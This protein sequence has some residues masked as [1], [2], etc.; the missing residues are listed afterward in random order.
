MLCSLNPLP[1]TNGDASF[2]PLFVAEFNR[3]RPQSRGQFSNRRRNRLDFID[4]CARA[5][6]RRTVFASPL[7]SLAPCSRHGSGRPLFLPSFL[8]PA[9]PVAAKKSDRCTQAVLTALVKA[10]AATALALRAKPS[11]R[12]V[13]RRCPVAVP[14]QGRAALALRVMPAL[15]TTVGRAELVQVARPAVQV[16][17]WRPPKVSS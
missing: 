2:V 4:I 16:A 7:V 12:A 9:R 17:R 11:A 13:A 6:P 3:Q 15:P 1:T 14:P 5:S 8:R 10:D